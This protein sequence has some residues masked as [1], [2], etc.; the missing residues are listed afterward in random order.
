[1]PYR[2]TNVLKSITYYFLFIFFL[3]SYQVSVAY[4]INDD[5]NE[6]EFEVLLNQQATSNFTATNQEYYRGIIIVDSTLPVAF[7]GMYRFSQMTDPGW[8]LFRQTIDWATN[9]QNHSTAKICFAPHDRTTTLQKE[10]TFT[11][12]R[13]LIDSMNF[14]S[15]NIFFSN[16]D[17]IGNIDYSSYD[18]VFNSGYSISSQPP[19][20]LNIIEQNVPFITTNASVA[21]D[22]GIGV[23]LEELHET[24]DFVYINDSSHSI[25][26]SYIPGLLI[27]NDSMWM[28]AVFPSGNGVAIVTA[29]D[30]Q[31][32]PP[33]L[34]SINQVDSSTAIGGTSLVTIDFSPGAAPLE[35]AGFELL[36]SYDTTVLSIISITQ[37]ELLDSCQWNH[38]AYFVGSDADCGGVP[39]SEDKIKIV[40]FADLF[41]SSLCNISTEGTL[42]NINF[43]VISDPFYE[44]SRASVY[45]NWYDC[46]DN[47]FSSSGGDTTFVSRNVLADFPNHIIEDTTFPTNS[48]MPDECI[49]GT[50]PVQRRINFANNS[51]VIEGCLPYSHFNDKGDINLN[52]IP[53]EIADA[54]LFSNYFTFGKDVFSVDQEN[55]IL[56]TDVNTDSLTLTLDDYVFIWRY[57]YGEF[58][59]SLDSPSSLTAIDTVLFTQDTINK[60]VSLSYPYSLR[61]VYLVFEGDLRPWG[62]GEDST[63]TPFDGSHTRVLLDIY[64]NGDTVFYQDSLFYY[65]GEGTLV[66]AFAAVNGINSIPTAI[67]GGSGSCCLNRGNF[68]GDSL[69][70][71]DISDLV[72]LV[73]YLFDTG[74]APPCFDEGDISADWSIDIAD[75]VFLVNFIF[76]HGPPP[77]ACQ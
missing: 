57:V 75:L 26:A 36:L 44:C 53:Y 24:R 76:S 62:W 73:S 25:T 35:T 7:F 9:Y 45:F 63:D 72:T 2:I 47:S 34:I 19:Y 70:Q 54:I 49:V 22:I 15:A 18:L 67:V 39:C 27:F 55:Q 33:A 66:G 5:L 43:Q 29:D 60:K 71:T 68:D 10:D 52:D 65:T 42:V 58:F 13:F 61:A 56:A 77:P 38:F 59:K 4:D 3:F 37:G 69:G 12:Y 74:T 28:D 21:L 14:D 46:G 20:A 30:G 8:D 50:Q 64:L 48:G 51:V 31:Y 41:H 6:T 23:N 40:A 32:Y 11:A 16:I 1:M 17:S